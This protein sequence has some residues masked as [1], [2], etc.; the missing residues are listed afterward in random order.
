MSKQACV[1]IPLAELKWM[2]EVV[3]GTH[4][5]IASYAIEGERGGDVSGIRLEDAQQCE[6]ELEYIQIALVT[7]LR[8]HRRRKQPAPAF[9]IAGGAQEFLNARMPFKKYLPTA[10]TP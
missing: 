6:T 4:A 1:S 9:S 5:T 8:D 10:I 7:R 3:G 2:L